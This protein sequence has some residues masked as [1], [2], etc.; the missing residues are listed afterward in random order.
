MISEGNLAPDFTLETDTG[1]TV[2]LTGFRGRPLVLFFYP[3]DDTP[4]CT[5]E[6]CAFRDAYAEFQERGAAIVGVS[7]DSTDS[8][9]R[10]KD[11]YSLPFVLLSDPEQKAAQA[12][13]VWREKTMYGRRRM[14]ILRSTFVIDADGVVSRAMYG[15]KPDGHA[16]DV[17]AALS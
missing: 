11:K 12:Y 16:D 8:H 2:S 6:A 4:G 13:D 14:G 5:K 7:P 10:F 17:L 3:R 1:E 9:V 15:V